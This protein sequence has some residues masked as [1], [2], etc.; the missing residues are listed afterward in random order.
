MLYHSLGGLIW[1]FWNVLS[2]SKPQVSATQTCVLAE[3]WQI[4]PTLGHLF[5]PLCLSPLSQWVQHTPTVWP[6]WDSV[7]WGEPTPGVCDPSALTQTHAQL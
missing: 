7:K 4:L 3:S 1:E 5:L 6:A 2:D